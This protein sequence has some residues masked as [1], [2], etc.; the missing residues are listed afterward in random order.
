[1]AGEPKAH[2]TVEGR[3]ATLRS[4]VSEGSH[5]GLAAAARHRHR[6]LR[7]LAAQEAAQKLIQMQG[8]AQAVVAAVA[9]VLG[10]HGEQ[11]QHVGR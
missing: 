7:V 4:S 9:V 8:D 10:K 6:V 1:V 5:V 2:S 11:E 3:D